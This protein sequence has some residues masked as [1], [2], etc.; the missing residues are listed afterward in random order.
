MKPEHLL[1]LPLALA[2]LAGIALY[3][4]AALA[5]YPFCTHVLRG[6]PRLRRR[7]A[8]LA[9]WCRRYSRL[10]GMRME[11]RG[12]LPASGLVV[13]N[14]LSYLDILAYGSVS[15]CAFVAKEDVRSWPLFGLMARLGATVFVTRT[16]ADDLHARIE[17]IRR[18]LE[19]G[20]PVVLFPEG[21][22]SGGAGVLPFRS[23]LLQAAA[24]K[25]V[26]PA[27]IAY[28]LPPGEGEPATHICYW[29]DMRFVPHLLRLLLIPRL[30]ASL[31]FRL[32]LQPSQ[33]RKQLAGHLHQEV[34]ALKE[35]S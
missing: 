3:G 11:I 31:R 18:L 7:V 26:K 17:E 25:T 35:A 9:F 21:T 15:P 5:S 8:W 10:L 13:S 30:F 29:A 28:T 19:A 12:A 14:H 22:S 16:R 2:R 33:N 27:A 20:I 1:R 24:G 4:L 6:E 23:S 32:P 34:L